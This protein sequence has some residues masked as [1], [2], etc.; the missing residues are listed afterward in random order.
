M[1]DKYTKLCDKLD[2]LKDDNEF[3]HILQDKIYRKFI[4]DVTNEKVKGNDIKKIADL[5][6]KRVFKYDKNR[7]YA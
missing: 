4:R 7:W 3:S 6:K 5:I 2:K 1:I